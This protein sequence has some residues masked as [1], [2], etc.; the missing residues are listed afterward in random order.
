MDAMTGKTAK[1]QA[2]MAEMAQAEQR[3]QI[4][5]ERAR[6][7]A[8]EAGQRRVRTGGRGMLAFIEEQLSSA[9]GG[10]RTGAGT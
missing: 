6:V 8:V 1:R 4:A 10:G 9:L 3:S 2:R 7:D 5:G